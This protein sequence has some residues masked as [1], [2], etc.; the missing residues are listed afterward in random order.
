VKQS[1]C[2]TKETI[3]S[4]QQQTLTKDGGKSRLALVTREKRASQKVLSL[5]GLANDL[6]AQ[7]S[8]RPLP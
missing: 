2:A 5:D 6:A 8:D 7:F 4:Y 3:S 1:S